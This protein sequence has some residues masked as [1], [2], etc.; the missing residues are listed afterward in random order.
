MGAHV[1]MACRNMEKGEDAKT[2]IETKV[3]GAKLTLLGLDLADLQSVEEFVDN[4]N[5]LNIPL[6]I[7]INNAG[8][9]A[10]PYRETA[11]GFE[12]QF[13]TNHLGHF[14]LTTLLKPKLIEGQPARVVV[15]SSVAHSFEGIHWKDISG[16]GTWYTGS[17]LSKWKAYGQSKTAN[18]LF[19]VELNRRMH[20]EGLNITANAV[21]PG[22]IKT[23]LFREVRGISGFVTSLGSFFYKTV[24]QGAATTVYVATAPELEG[25]GG[26]YFA[27]CNEASAKAYATNPRYAGRLWNLSEE[28]IQKVRKPNEEGAQEVKEESKHEPEQSEHIKTNSNL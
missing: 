16:K 18:L 26:K 14:H 20:T 3:E 11:D 9:M 17:T 15:L 25:I 7:L 6:H 1:V 8:I 10:M 13:G 2:E 5:A 19:A 28:M 23:E 22:V 12:M 4:F 24:P 21:H 27:D